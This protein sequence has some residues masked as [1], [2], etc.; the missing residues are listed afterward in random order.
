MKN[1]LFVL[2]LFCT[3]TAFA[4]YSNNTGGNSISNQV[5]AYQFESH[6]GHAAYAPMSEERNILPAT[7]YLSAQGSRP[8]SDFAQPDS[9]SLGTAARELRK[10]HAAVAKKSRVVWVNN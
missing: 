8:A 1:I 6:T 5:Q 3:A 2:C 4:Q 10:Q 7:T 9:V